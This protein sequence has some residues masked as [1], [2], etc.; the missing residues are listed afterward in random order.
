MLA[1]A[2]SFTLFENYE[3][4][5]IILRA[6]IEFKQPMVY[7]PQRISTKWRL[8]MYWPITKNEAVTL[9]LDVFQADP[10]Y[11]QPAL[12]DPRLVGVHEALVKRVADR[13][14]ELERPLWKNSACSKRNDQRGLQRMAGSAEQSTIGPTTVHLD[15]LAEQALESK[16]YSSCSGPMSLCSTLRAERAVCPKSSNV[17]KTSKK[18]NPTPAAK[19]KRQ[20]VAGSMVSVSSIALPAFT[21]A[22]P[23]FVLVLSKG[24][25][26]IPTHWQI[27]SHKFFSFSS[28]IS[29]YFSNFVHQRSFFV[30][31]LSAF[32]LHGQAMDGKAKGNT[33][34]GR[35]K[36]DVGSNRARDC[37]GESTNGLPAQS[38]EKHVR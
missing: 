6:V 24:F 31:S 10:A 22:Y 5:I 35:V 9:L 25:S 18:R 30:A 29:G 36:T 4:A 1:L 34:I 19:R 27:T 33:A 28:I 37:G 2:D 12:L 15:H 16:S 14:R 20:T 32:P 11:C 21:A 17:M 23:V 3:S 7:R 13:S 26:K 38:A 8:I